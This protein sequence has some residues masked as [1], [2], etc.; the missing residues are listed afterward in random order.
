L[1]DIFI[2]VKIAG[3]K[4]YCISVASTSPSLS[5]QDLD[6]VL[7]EVMDAKAKWKLIGLKLKVPKGELDSIERDGS[8]DLNRLMEVLAKWLQSRKNTTWKAL[9]D[10]M[11]AATV[12]REDLKQKILKKHP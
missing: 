2:A 4:S 7:E 9:A 3:F 5:D 8:D 11:G 6:A 1:V 12:G 10:A